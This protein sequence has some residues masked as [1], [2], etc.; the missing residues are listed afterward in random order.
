MGSLNR[1]ISF[2]QWKLTDLSPY[3]QWNPRSNT[4]TQLTTRVSR[5]WTKNH[6]RDLYSVQRE[7]WFWCQQF[8]IMWWTKWVQTKVW[9]AIG[10]SEHNMSHRISTSHQ[11][12]PLSSRPRLEIGHVP[13]PD[14]VSRSVD[15]KDSLSGLL[16]RELSADD[17]PSRTLAWTEVRR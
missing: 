2:R 5:F 17:G 11:P 7:H 8:G 12:I 4:P 10:H 16:L 13:L 14:R 3:L 15:H 9:Q 6:L 1:T